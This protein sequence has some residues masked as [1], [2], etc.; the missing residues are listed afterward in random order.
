MKQEEG[1]HDAE[2][3]VLQRRRGRQTVFNRVRARGGSTNPRLGEALPL[4]RPDRFHGIGTVAVG[5]EL[6]AAVI[7]FICCSNSLGCVRESG[8]GST[9]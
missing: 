8:G 6:H 1:F 9:G 2:L 3:K 7:L 4:V 5:C